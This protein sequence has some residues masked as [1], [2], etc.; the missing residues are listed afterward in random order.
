MFGFINIQI[1][2][3]VRLKIV[4]IEIC[5]KLKDSVFLNVWNLEKLFKMKNDQNH[6][7][8]RF[9]KCLQL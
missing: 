4:Q 7:M 3:L 9:W 2:K 6:K 5:L 8:F 1:W